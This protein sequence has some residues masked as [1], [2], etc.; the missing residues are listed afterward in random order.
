MQFWAKKKSKSG[1]KMKLSFWN[2]QGQNSRVW[3]TSSDQK[4][5]TAVGGG[6]DNFL[7]PGDPIPPGKKNPDCLKSYIWTVW[8]HLKDWLKFLGVP[9]F[10]CWMLVN[11]DQCGRSDNQGHKFGRIQN[12][13]IKWII[14]LL[15]KIWKTTF[16]QE[17]FNEIW[18]KVGEHE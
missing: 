16:P 9:A 10:L 12:K 6:G 2:F 1:R 17:F 4:V 3:V 7:P 13:I 5:G 15:A 18:L 11:V 14:F 8:A